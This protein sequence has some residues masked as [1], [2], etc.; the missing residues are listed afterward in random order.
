MRYVYFCNSC[1]WGGIDDM[2]GGHEICITI[3][4]FVCMYQLSV[5][6]VGGGGI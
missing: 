6:V 4:T 2:S 5:T 1:G 3:H